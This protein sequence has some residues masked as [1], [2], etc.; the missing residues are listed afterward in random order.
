MKNQ[1]LI[2]D[3]DI[4]VAKRIKYS[5][6]DENTYVYYTSSIKEA[7]SLFASHTYAM[8]IMDIAHSETDGLEL[9]RRLQRK[10][11]VPILV[12]SSNY[13]KREE[14]EVLRAGADK[15]LGKPL[16]MER[17]LAHA[18]AIMRRYMLDA[19]QGRS[20]ILVAGSG[21]KIDLHGHRVFWG[22]Q[23]IN[24][25]PIQ[26]RLIC[27]LANNMGAVLTKEQ[28]YATGWSE[29]FE[30]NIDEAVKFQIKE[31]RRKFSN[32][33]AEDFIK[34]VWGVGYQLVLKEK[35]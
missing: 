4:E 19:G 1:V 28:M 6:Q 22:E 14:C 35:R 10:S 30:V 27:S 11:P 15:Y 9:L 20:Y 24:L 21:L 34:T 18:Q 23:K 29:D 2:I 31:L 5:L 16:D 13:S 26:Y 32:A 3:S 7:L 25:T 12:L 8:V 17:C 33:G